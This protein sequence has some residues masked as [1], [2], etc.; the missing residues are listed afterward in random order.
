MG[1]IQAVGFRVSCGAS[2]IAAADVSGATDRRRAEPGDGLI[3]RALDSA[4]VLVVVPEPEGASAGWSKILGTDADESHRITTVDLL[5]QGLSGFSDALTHCCGSLS[6]W[7]RLSVRKSSKRILI[8]TVDV[9]HSAR[10]SRAATRSASR[11]SFRAQERAVEDV[12]V[13]G[14]LMT[15]ALLHALRVDDA[16]ILSPGELCESRTQRRPDSAFDHLRGASRTSRTVRIPEPPA[17][18]RPS[19]RRPTWHGPVE[20]RGCRA[21]PSPR[22]RASRR[23]WISSKPSWRRAW[24]RRRRRCT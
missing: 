6:V 10:R 8:A 21:C 20:E 19:A 11:S 7:D 1:S 9:S 24:W 18:Q 17:L 16:R 12:G 3:H 13:E 22:R 2:A 14:L 15:D 23:A 4:P 5:E